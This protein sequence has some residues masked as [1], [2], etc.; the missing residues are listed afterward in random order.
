MLKDLREKIARI[1]PGQKIAYITDVAGNPDNFNSIIK[2]AKDSD[3]LF[4]E[5]AFLFGDREV[6]GRKYHLT[7]AE[8]GK[9]AR[10]ACVKRLQPF[11][12]SP[13][14]RGRASE[15][16]EEAMASFG[17]GGDEH[18]AGRFLKGS[19]EP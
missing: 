6:A 18:S 13:R 11:H 4:I 10:K 15:L 1:S 14:Y 16:E 17:F 12:F 5:T 9:L 19:Y 2:L 3:I 7:A 8:A